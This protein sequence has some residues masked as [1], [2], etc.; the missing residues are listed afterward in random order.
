[1]NVIPQDQLFTDLTVEQ[2]E[3]VAAGVVT[4]ADASYGFAAA[5]FVRTGPGSFLANLNVGDSV[6]DGN[7][8][9]ARFEGKAT[10]GSLLKTPTKRPDLDGAAGSFTAY[11]NLR[12]SFSKNIKQLRVLLYRQNRSGADLITAGNWANF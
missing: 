2:A 5:N 10:D 1:M 3:T 9:Y 4:R 12:G 11:T 6:A 7:Q 8:V